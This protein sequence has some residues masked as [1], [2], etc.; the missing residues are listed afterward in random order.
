M[1]MEEFKKYLESLESIETQIVYLKYKYSWEENWTYS[2]EILEVDMNADGYYVWTSD[3]NEGQE[4][5]EILGCIALYDIYVPKFQKDTE[6]NRMSKDT[7]YRQDAVDAI[8]ELHDKPNAWLDLAVEALEK[9]PSAESE[10]AENL[11]LCKCYI[12]DKDG[13]RH[14]VI[15]TDD[16][17]RV[18]GWE[19]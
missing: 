19:I 4:D 9:L 3:W 17:R 10:I 13:L 2:N 15:Y 18:T 11:H 8:N 14:E 7:I 1:R 6:V 16:I 5:I 12:T